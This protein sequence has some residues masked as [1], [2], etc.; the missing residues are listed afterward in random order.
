MLETNQLSQLITVAD[1]KTLSKAAEILHISQPALTRSI[2]KL[3]SELNVTLFDRQKNKITLNKTGELA[4]SHARRILADVEQMT[5]SIQAFERSLHTISIG[6]CAPAPIVE[7]LYYLTE[8]FATMTFSSETVNPDS[9]VLGLKNNT[10]QIIITNS[11]VKD[12]EICCREFCR[13]QLFLTIPPAHPLAAKK[14]GI[15]ADEL[16]GETMLLFKEIGIWESFIKA[17]MSQTDFI[18]QDRDD[19]F[20][21]LIRASALPAFAT[22]LTLKRNDRRQNRIII[23][24]LDDEAKMTFY[25]STLNKNKIYLPDTFSVHQ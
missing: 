14:D 16:A 7:L 25:C 11:P 19:A 22:N 4:V 5:Q 1:T 3:E 18:I 10:Y 6:S 8:K 24:F 15:F 23:P 21:A 13:E 2:Q 12:S 9:L 20:N 17:K